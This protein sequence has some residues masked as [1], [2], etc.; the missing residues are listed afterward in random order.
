MLVS[1]KLEGQHLFDFEIDSSVVEEC[2]GS[3]W[4]QVPQQRWCCDTTDPIEGNASLHHCYDNPQDGCDY[5]VYRHDPLMTGAPFSISFRIRHAYAPSSQNNWQLALGAT[6]SEGMESGE[7]EANGGVP[8]ILS[9]L[10]V[11]VNLTG[12]DDLVKIWHVDQGETEV[13]L[14]TMLNY[15]EQVGTDQAPL[16]LLSMAGF[17]SGR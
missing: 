15:Q 4:K 11:G 7:S 17:L 5:L 14:T 1:F 6:F 13:K 8:E 12:S 2:P 16:F 3:A 10:V 9:G